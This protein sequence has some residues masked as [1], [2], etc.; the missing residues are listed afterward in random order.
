MEVGEG[1]S[2]CITSTWKKIY[3]ENRFPIVDVVGSTALDCNFERTI[4]PET[5]LTVV[6]SRLTR[7]FVCKVILLITASHETFNKAAFS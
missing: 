4:L 7:C 1:A 2:I 3:L 5:H 6:V